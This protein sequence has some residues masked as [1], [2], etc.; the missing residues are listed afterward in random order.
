M[1]AHRIAKEEEE[2]EDRESVPVQRKEARGVN[3]GQSTK[4]RSV[5]KAQ[6]C[7]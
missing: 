2:E 7:S 6:E 3:A 1:R 5:I 4:C